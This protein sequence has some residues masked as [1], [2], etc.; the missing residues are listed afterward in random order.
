MANERTKDESEQMNCAQLALERINEAYE[1]EEQAIQ[2]KAEAKDDLR[3]YL[4]DALPFEANPSITIRNGCFVVSCYPRPALKEIDN[5]LEEEVEMVMPLEF[6]IGEESEELDRDDLSSDLQR[7]RVKNVKGL[8]SDIE[9]EY[10][11]GAPVDLVLSRA[12]EVGL[13]KSK[14]EHE[15]DKL[16]QKGEVYEPTTDTLRTT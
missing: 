1:Y 8:I 13:S 11:D 16:K 4:S 3:E 15:I 2:L 6:R 9:E 12:Y 10:E 7:M 5:D 14:M